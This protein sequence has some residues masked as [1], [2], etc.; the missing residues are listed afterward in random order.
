M[1]H[2]SSG[3]IIVE[4]EL[5]VVPV[6]FVSACA[7]SDTMAMIATIPDDLEGEAKFTRIY[8]LNLQTDELWHYV[9]WP[10]HEVA[11]VCLRRGSQNRPRAGCA[12]TGGGQIEIANSQGATYEDIA[13]AGLEGSRGLGDLTKI[14]EV[15]SHLFACG[16]MGQVYRRD[17]TGWVAIDDHLVKAGRAL[18]EAVPAADSDRATQMRQRVERLRALPNLNAIDGSNEKDLY[19]C[20]FGGNLY[21]YTDSWRK[22]DIGRESILTSIHAVSPEETWVAGQDGLV[23][24]GNGRDGFHT[25][26]SLF[27]DSYIWSIRR[28]R[29]ETYVGTL[30]G[31]YRLVR[32]RAVLVKSEGLDDTTPIIAIDSAGDDA[33]WI[34]SDRHAFLHDGAGVKMYRHGDNS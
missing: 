28:F 18:L 27:P 32:D 22:I 16:G 20:G 7:V 33:M 13:G 31:L 1:N 8:Y 11:S 24:R 25:V 2:A 9:D 21:H 12:M 17:P 34:V 23:I 26:G 10:D 29:G 4:S 19:V 30:H 14:K 5:M 6:R 3:M 15:G